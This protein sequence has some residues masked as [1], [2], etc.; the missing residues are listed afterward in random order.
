MQLQATITPDAFAALPD[1]TVLGKDAFAEN[2][3]ENLFFLNVPDSEARKLAFSLNTELEKLRDNNREL[4]KQKGE[5]NSKVKDFEALGKTPEEIKELL[6][7][8]RPEELM[9]LIADHKTE[10]DTLKQSYEGPMQALTADNERLKSQIADSVSRAAISKLRTDYDLNDTADYILR[11]FI[12]AVP[13]DDGYQTRVFENGQ[14]ALVA[15]QPMTPEQLIKGFQE[16]KRFSAMF[17]VSE[18]GGTGVTRSAANA[19]LQ[20]RLEGLSAVE[21][22]KVARQNGATT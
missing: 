2:T 16:Q 8:K 17:N 11:D 19:G 5:V 7:S 15:G 10:M 22:L 20:K 13:S 1:S 18:G 12:K 6:D 14:E 3:K 9:K 21:R 4:L